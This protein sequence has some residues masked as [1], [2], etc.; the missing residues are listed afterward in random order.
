MWRHW[1]IPGR[2]AA[3]SVPR[4]SRLG[5]GDRPHAV[6]SRRAD[7]RHRWRRRRDGFTDGKDILVAMHFDST[8]AD[9]TNVDIYAV[10]G[11]ALRQITTSPGAD[12]RRGIHQ[13]T[14]GPATSPWSARDSRLIGSV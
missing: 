9:N 14:T 4:G 3:A 11:P 7:D 8:V 1:T 13:I 12:T 10:D 5:K 6:G 2:E